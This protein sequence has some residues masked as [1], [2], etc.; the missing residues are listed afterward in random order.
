M[1]FAQ[2][3][4]DDTFTTKATE[5]NKKSTSAKTFKPL[6]SKF[7]ID[8]QKSLGVPTSNSIFNVVVDESNEGY[9][10]VPLLSTKTQTGSSS[11]V[12]M[13]MRYEPNQDG[14]E[15]TFEL[16]LDSYNLVETENQLM[17]Y[18]QIEDPDVEGLFESF[19]CSVELDRAVFGFNPSEKIVI[20]NYNGYGSL[21]AGSEGVNRKNY[22]K[23]NIGDQVGP[24]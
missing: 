1:G 8:N 20:Q 9:L 5:S 19:T 12:N 15:M 11:D 7:Y 24:D 14:T 3:Y 18:A 13:L 10:S 23:L 22:D 4:T 6:S 21:K 17:L 2:A 16:K